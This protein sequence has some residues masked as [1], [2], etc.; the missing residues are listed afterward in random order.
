[1]S[2][3]SLAESA[4]LGGQNG[5]NDILRVPRLGTQTWKGTLSAILLALLNLIAAQAAQ[6]AD[7]YVAAGGTDSATALSAGNG[8]AAAPW[9]SVGAAFASGQLAGGD[10]LLLEPGEHGNLTIR[11][12]TFEPPLTITP[13]TGGRVHVNKIWIHESSGLIIERLA[14]W[15]LAPLNVEGKKPGNPLVHAT[16]SSSRITFRGLDVRGA[17]DADTRYLDW[18]KDDWL[19]VWRAAGV[20]LAG[21]DQTLQNSVL[22]G[23][24]N[25]ITAAGPRARVLDNE[26]RGFS[27]DGLRGLGSGSVFRGNVVRDCVKVD[28]NHDDGF[29]S[30]VSLPG[31]GDRKVVSD[32]SV[33]GNVILEWT[34]PANHPLR[35]QL[36]GISLF[37]GPYRNWI[38]SNNLIAV[39]AYHGIALY[40]TSNFEVVHNTVVQIDGKPGKSPWIMTKNTTGDASGNLIANNAAMNIK[41]DPKTA[42]ARDNLVIRFPIPMFVN[43]ATHDYRPVP[44]SALVGAADPSLGEKQDLIGTQ[45]PARPAIGALEP[46]S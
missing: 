14:V 36:Q 30:W 22:T 8:S 7:Y 32:V 13:A 15:P 17:P 27:K 38:I 40:G 39:S 23:I 6:T 21:P 42:N 26:V 43:V 25:G 11:G 1:M 16:A 46:P 34:G 4:H 37:N 31:K 2:S 19:H 3:L 44:G 28:G 20:M 35:G 12:A 33:I 5:P 24:S 29:Q 9:P 45:R 41:L 18:S 10:R